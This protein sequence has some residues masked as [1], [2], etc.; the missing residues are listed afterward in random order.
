MSD[1]NFPPDSHL[2]FHLVRA[3]V[4]ETYQAMDKKAVLLKIKRLGELSSEKRRLIYILL[5]FGYHER[6]GYDTVAQFIEAVFPICK[7]EAY[8]EHAR[9]R[10]ELVFFKGDLEKIGTVR[11]YHLDELISFTRGKFSS[12]EELRACYNTIWERLNSR[13]A[14]NSKKFK[15]DDFIDEVKVYLGLAVNKADNTEKKVPINSSR[16]TT[17]N[18]NPKSKTNIK[19]P[20]SKTP[21]ESKN[22]EASNNYPP[23]K[24]PIDLGIFSTKSCD[25]FSDEE[26]NK[27][28]QELFEWLSHKRKKEIANFINAKIL[29]DDKSKLFSLLLEYRRTVNQEKYRKSVQSA[30]LIAPNSHGK[31][32]A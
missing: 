4:L 15:K 30:L 6:L 16:R 26:F 24:P 13:Q 10:V 32:I 21:A 11:A 29:R 25:D 14:Y 1:F 17:K 18:A 12:I 27:L 20:V 7:Q 8:K 3:D 5:S 22:K 31:R 2:E 9:A 19:S 28:Q 23:M